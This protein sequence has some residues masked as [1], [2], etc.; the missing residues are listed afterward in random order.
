M[1]K[2]VH[3]TVQAQ[4]SVCRIGSVAVWLAI[5]RSGYCWQTGSWSGIIVSLVRS[6]DAFGDSSFFPGKTK[7]QAPTQAPHLQH[8]WQQ[9][10]ALFEGE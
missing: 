8:Y 7:L 6:G 5:F 2:L 1:W 4:P 3:L 10:H 9:G